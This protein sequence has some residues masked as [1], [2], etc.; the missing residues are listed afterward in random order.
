M[1]L[2]LVP[3]A[4]VHNEYGLPMCTVA[5]LEPGGGGSESSALN[6]SVTAMNHVSPCAMVNVKSLWSYLLI[7]AR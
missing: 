6:Q 2:Q 4:A 5:G 3:K 7:I 1:V